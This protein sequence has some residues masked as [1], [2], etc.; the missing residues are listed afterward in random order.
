MSGMLQATFFFGYIAVI[1]YAFVLLLGA[2]GWWA[3]YFFLKKIYGAIK[4]D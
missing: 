2:T 1:S 4:S 3:A